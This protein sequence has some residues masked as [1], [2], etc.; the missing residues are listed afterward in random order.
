MSA[1]WPIKA[2][3]G[4]NLK[5]SLDKM[6]AKRSRSI[7]LETDLLKVKKTDFLRF[8]APII[9][10]L[11]STIFGVT[12]YYFLPKALLSLNQSLMLK[13]FMFILMGMIFGLC[14]IALNFQTILEHSF[15]KPLKFRV[16][17]STI[18]LIKNNLKHHR[19]KNI[20]T[21]LLFS[22]SFG[23][24]IFLVVCY[25][26][27]LKSLQIETVKYKGALMHLQAD[28]PNIL[29]PQVF[30][31]ILQNL[32]HLVSEFSY[33]TPML[34]DNTEKHV[35]QTSVTDYRRMQDQE[36]EMYGV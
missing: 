32:N 26:L 21:S 23:F 12:I 29:T 8:Q 30:D 11:I 24:I 20:I 35:G 31:P 27:V 6:G 17:K 25:T 5:E 28:F 36:I 1:I 3:V 13:I 34:S 7:E 14:L 19:R 9:F 18:T 22:I 15:L 2:A 10:G 16:K 4:R 33:V